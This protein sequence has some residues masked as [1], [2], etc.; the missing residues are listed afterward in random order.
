MPNIY[1]YSRPMLGFHL[2]TI[3]FRPVL[4]GI[5][6]VSFY[7]KKQS[8]AISYERRAYEDSKTMFR[9]ILAQ[10]LGRL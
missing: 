4:L 1:K 5:L 8:Y 9:F 2:L 10:K 6:Y 7:E 3:I